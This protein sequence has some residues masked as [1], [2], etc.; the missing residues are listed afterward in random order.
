MLNKIF[1][2]CRL[3]ILFSLLLF[4]CKKNVSENLPKDQLTG[5]WSEISTGYTRVLIFEPGN[6]ITIQIKNSQYVDWHIK[7]TGKYAIEGDNL[8]VNITEQSERQSQGTIVKSPVNLRWFDNGKFGIENF[9]LTIKYKTYPADA[10]VDTESKFAKIVA[11][12]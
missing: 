5:A 11:I 10:P 12:D 3:I 2:A 8:N 4:S 9:V 7:L 6:R 1:N